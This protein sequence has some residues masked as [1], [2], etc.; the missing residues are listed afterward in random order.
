M[1]KGPKVGGSE[2]HAGRRKGDPGAWT[3]RS[4]RKAHRGLRR[5]RRALSHMEIWTFSQEPGKL[6]IGQRFGGRGAGGES[7]EGTVDS[8]QM[9]SAR[10]STPCAAVEW[11]VAL[12]K[13]W[14]ACL[15]LRDCDC[16][17]WRHGGGL[18]LSLE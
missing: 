4:Q 18:P 5:P 15:S 7:G 14:P 17:T 11:M 8:Q 16:S 10:A 13:C 6:V 3:T 12:D 9:L 1:C 2:V